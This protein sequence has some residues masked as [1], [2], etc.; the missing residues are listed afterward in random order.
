MF[1]GWLGPPGSAGDF[2]KD[3]LFVPD[4]NILLGCYRIGPDAREQL[5]G[6]LER[7]RDRL[8]TPHQSA[9]EFVRNRRR[10]LPDQKKRHGDAKKL[11]NVSRDRAA[12]A[13]SDAVKALTD[14]R[15]T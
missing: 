1:S 7:H 12:A 3:G 13:L 9:L 4:A 2:F 8:W 11:M 10:V 6:T 14:Y 15:T 5:L